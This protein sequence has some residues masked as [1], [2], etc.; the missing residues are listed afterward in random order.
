[1]KGLGLL[2]LGDNK[3]AAVLFSEILDSDINH[4]GAQ[5]HLKMCHLKQN[6]YPQITHFLNNFSYLN[7]TN[8]Q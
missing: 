7:T 2:G 8:Q 1:M 6:D 3:G 4:Q 5:I